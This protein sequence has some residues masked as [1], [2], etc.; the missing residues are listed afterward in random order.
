MDIRHHT[1]VVISFYD[2]RDIDNLDKLLCS[3][4]R[5]DAGADYSVCIV[6][7]RTSDVKISPGFNVDSILYRNNT[8]MNIGAWDF[9]W[10]K[11]PGFSDYLFLQDEC[12]I[13][14]DGWISAFQEAAREPKVGLVGEALNTKWDQSWDRLKKLQQDICLP[15][16]EINGCKA[17]R[18]DVYLKFLSDH[19][20]PAGSNGKHMRSLVWFFRHDV[21]KRIDGFPGGGNYGECI[22]SEIGVSKKIESL[23]LSV[24]QVKEMPFYFIR[25]LEWNQD[26]VASEYSHKSIRAK[27]K[28]ELKNENKRLNGLLQTPSWKLIMTL[29]IKKI[30]DD[31]QCL[32]RKMGRM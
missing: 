19:N 7:N 13:C 30:R 32:I 3:M 4:Q 15:E 5:H 21:M 8:G 20:V 16:H 22:A 1:L 18:V 14:K 6:V 10:R 9:G 17:N 28:N 25:H 29:A 23:G 31:G 26:S 12:Y 2:R 27:Q 24:I 11:N